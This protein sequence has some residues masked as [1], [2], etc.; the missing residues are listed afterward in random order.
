MLSPMSLPDGASTIL[1]LGD[2]HDHWREADRRFLEAGEQELAMFVGDLGDE[3]VDIVRS[4]A[5][6]RCPKAVMLGNH[7]AWQSFSHKSPTPDL[8]AILEILDDD[9]LAYAVREAPRAGVSIVGARPFSWGG[10]GL[11]NPEVYEQIYNVK[12]MADSTR[13]I[14][15]AARRAKHQDLVLLAHNGPTGLS[16]QPHHI[17]GKDFGN[18]PGGDWGDLDLAE[19]MTEIEYLGFRIPCVVAGHMHSRLARPNGAQRQR[20]VRRRDT[21]FVNPAVVPRLR[22]DKD[23]GVLAHFLRLGFA[24][25]RV[26]GVEEIWVDEVGR[27][28]EVVTPTIVDVD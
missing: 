16:T 7:D 24:N 17:Y 25:G 1:V 13:A 2:L 18:A 12:T 22:P 11:R 6:L 26:V 5:E 27:T 28:H 10:K 8:N 20:F 14:V 23:A 19:A 21:L 3:N 9:H 15:A 4:I